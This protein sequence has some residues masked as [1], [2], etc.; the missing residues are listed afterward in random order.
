MRNF[1]NLDVWKSGM[2]IVKRVYLLCS[3]LPKEEKYGLGS[4]MKRC[5]VS[6]PSNITEGS[7]RNS[8]KEFERFLNIAL[9]KRI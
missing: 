6:I 2:E 7:S 1:R 3:K 9:V 8:S 5:S 4:Q